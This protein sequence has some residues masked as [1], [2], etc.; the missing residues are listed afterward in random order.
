[1]T[2]NLLLVTKMIWVLPEKVV[3][4][5]GTCGVVPLNKTSYVISSS[6]S[7]KNGKTL[8]LYILHGVLS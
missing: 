6:L 3:T 1:M 5:G 2:L 4:S 7:H 8:F